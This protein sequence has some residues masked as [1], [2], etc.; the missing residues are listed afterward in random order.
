MNK[1]KHYTS[2]IRRSTR[3]PNFGFIQGHDYLSPE[4]VT[5][6][7]QWV[8]LDDLEV[9]VEFEQLFAGL[10][11]DRQALS[12]ATGRMGFFVLMKIL[13]IGKGDE[14]ILQGYT[15]SVMPNAIWRTGATPVFVDIDPDTFGS[16]AE[17][18]DKKITPNTR[19]IVAQHSFGIPCKIDEIVEIGKRHNIFVLEDSA[20]ALDSSLDG[21]K[22]GN[23][24]DAALFSIDHSK[25]LNSLIGGFIYTNKKELYKEI[26]N[27]NENIPHLDK[28]HQKRL[29]HQ[30]L[31]ERK[32]YN[33][34][35]YGFGKLLYA[36]KSGL[37]ASSNSYSFLE[38][39][40]SKNPSNESIAYPYPAKLPAF[41]ARLGLYELK[42]WGGEKERRKKLLN[43]YITLSE[44]LGLKQFLPAAY[45]DPR[46]EIVP[47]RFVFIHP[48]S[49]VIRN[50]MSKYVDV[51]WFWFQK[52]IICCNDPEE[53]GYEYGSCPISESVGKGVINWPCTL[54]HEY[55]NHL[56]Q[57]LKKVFSK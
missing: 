7:E 9:V 50:K 2:A 13:G 43:D 25:P 19:M 33:P 41:L 10:I 56:I 26:K 36:L 54:D 22:V 20:I 15:C 52:P 5:V 23:W 27:Y 51:D 53:L 32:Y 30:L 49:E 34:R 38:A 42:R 55:D 18:I 40:Y 35:K 28:D 8:G 24:G 37:S 46:L 31:F 12:F 21:V 17:H 6:L 48:D 11:G 39:D 3:T 16:S 45:L 47:L 14:V 57:M 4:E 1:L 44:R 29:F